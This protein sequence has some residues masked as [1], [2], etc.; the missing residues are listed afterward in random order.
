MDT[1]PKARRQTAAAR[2][3]QGAAPKRKATARPAATPR[4]GAAAV[5]LWIRLTLP[6]I[7]QIGPG[8]IEL[9]R[10][11][12]EHQ[13]ISAAARAMSMS[14]RR[15]WLLVDDMNAAFARPVVAKWMGGRAHGGATLTPTGE[16]L[17][18]SYDAV[19]ARAESASRELL[20]ELAGIT[21]R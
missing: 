12:H 17:V 19:I 2:Q 16:K 1:A 14:Y 5:K 9:L 18:A 6:G 20:Q 10:R 3:A 13:S 8:K 21:S 7:G 11:I 15:A 4:A